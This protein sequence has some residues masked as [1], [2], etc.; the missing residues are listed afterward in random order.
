MVIRSVGICLKPNQPQL[1]DVVRTL[2]GWLVER[3][4]QYLVTRTG[5]RR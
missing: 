1:A 4:L 3:G 5:C 2:E